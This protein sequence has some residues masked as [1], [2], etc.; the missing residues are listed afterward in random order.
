MYEDLKTQNYPTSGRGLMGSS[1]GQLLREI[2]G[3]F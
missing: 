2:K 3:W 1:D